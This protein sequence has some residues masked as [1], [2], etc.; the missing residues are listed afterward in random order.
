MTGADQIQLLRDVIAMLDTFQIYNIDDHARLQARAEAMVEVVDASAALRRA[1]AIL[2]ADA[3]LDKRRERRRAWQ[4]AMATKER[5]NVFVDQTATK[6]L[7]IYTKM[8]TIKPEQYKPE[9]RDDD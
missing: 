7:E 5:R 6:F 9:R 2:V 1:V 3:A 8:R 4:A